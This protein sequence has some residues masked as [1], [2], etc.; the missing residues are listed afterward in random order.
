MPTSQDQ[1]KSGYSNDLILG[2]YSL[3][4][5]YYLCGFFE[6]AETISEGLCALDENFALSRLLIAAIH[7]E[8]GNFTNAANHFRIASQNTDYANQ[9]RVG[10]LNCYIGQKDIARARSLADELD[11]ELDTFTP[12]LTEFYEELIKAILPQ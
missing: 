6:E 1:L 4:R 12:E 11:K 3:A 2:L 9:S 7:L 8:Q 10:I 5:N